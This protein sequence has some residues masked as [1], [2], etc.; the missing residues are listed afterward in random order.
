MAFHPYTMLFI[1]IAFLLC[2]SFVQLPLCFKFLFFCHSKSDLLQSGTW[3]SNKD[4]LEDRIKPSHTYEAVM[5]TSDDIFDGTTLRVTT[6]IV[7]L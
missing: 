7:S 1:R 4:R 5:R 3:R 6:K 2:M